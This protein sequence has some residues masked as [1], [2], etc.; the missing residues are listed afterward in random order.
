MFSN[1]TITAK[2]MILVVVPVLFELAFVLVLS[3]MLWSASQ[4]FDQL[5]T[6]NEV[7]MRLHQIRLTCATGA[8]VLT[9]KTST[10]DQQLI[11]L[12]KMLAMVDNPRYYLTTIGGG[13]TELNQLSDSGTTLKEDFK[14]LLQYLRSILINKS[15]IRSQAANF[16][17][18]L[19]ALSI[20][21]R[22]FTQRILSIEMQ[23]RSQEPRELERVRNSLTAWLLAGVLVSCVVSAGLA[24]F[25]TTDVL[26]RLRVIENNARLLASG[27]PLAAPQ[28]GSD[29]IARLDAALHESGAILKEAR[30]R[31]L[32]ILDN[33]ATVIC[34][35]DARLRFRA[36]S[37]AT[38]K[39]W[40]YPSDD[41]LGMSLLALLEQSTLEPTKDAFQKI[42]DAC[43]EGEVE[44]IM[45]CRD[46]TWRNCRWSVRWLPADGNFFCVV[47]DVTAL[48]AVQKLKQNFLA[49]VSH[50]L[51]TPLTSVGISLEI[52]SSGKRGPLPQSVSTLIERTHRSSIR[53]TE[54]VNELLELEKLEAGKMLLEA[55]NVSTADICEEATANL[56]TMAKLADVKVEGPQDDVVLVA[57]GKRL[58]QVM[59]NLLS[60]AIKFSPRSSRVTITVKPEGN[61]VVFR[62]RDEGP[63]VPADQRSLIFERFCQSRTLSNVPMK[64]TGLGL[65]I[66]KA[67]VEAHGGTVG[68]DCERDKGSTFWFRLPQPE[69][70]GQ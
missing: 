31:E 4:Q 61:F 20:E 28:S 45:R 65:A 12:D 13:L 46:G 42:A 35:L 5:D 3:Q 64:S 34:S 7:L 40:Q 39:L 53:L 38:S 32:A 59:M 57:D 19:Q 66:V 68:L 24:Y 21:A 54:L 69:K 14:A 27:V 30:R 10:P 16:Q 36:A 37:A 47:H 50:D 18:K 56:S 23:Q 25:F 49:I 11:E 55:S 48:R 43:G 41:L 2:G 22:D 51:R 52:L 44:N 9:D 15:D 58:T 6:A 8:L 67:I 63:G 33:A 62:V 70:D 1:L 17:G 60:N 26:K 29:E